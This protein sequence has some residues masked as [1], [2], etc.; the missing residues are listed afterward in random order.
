M[1]GKEIIISHC[2]NVNGANI[3]KDKLLK[4]YPEAKIE[5]RQTAL[6]TG[7]YAE[8]GGLIVTIQD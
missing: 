3:M 8:K 7:Y 2:L 4:Q 1:K 6:L 5:T